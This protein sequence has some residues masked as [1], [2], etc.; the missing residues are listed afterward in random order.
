MFGSVMNVFGAVWEESVWWIPIAAVGGFLGVFGFIIFAVIGSTENFDER[1]RAYKAFMGQCIEH[2][3]EA[4]CSQFWHYDR[5]D[6][7]GR[8]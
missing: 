5:K 1:N 6:L 2:H 8:K 7:G 4:R 3:T